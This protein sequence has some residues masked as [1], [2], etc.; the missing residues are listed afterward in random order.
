LAFLCITQDG[1]LRAGNCRDQAITLVERSY[2]TQRAG[3]LGS[4]GSFWE[5]AH[6]ASRNQPV[7]TNPK[8]ALI[9]LSARERPSNI[10]HAKSANAHNENTSTRPLLLGLRPRCGFVSFMSKGLMQIIAGRTVEAT[11]PANLNWTVLDRTRRLSAGR[12]TGRMGDAIF[13]NDVVS[14]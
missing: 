1:L 12:Q 5:D 2:G 7:P 3:S 14:G 10:D 8:I 11:L 6:I 13:A 4:S 9:T